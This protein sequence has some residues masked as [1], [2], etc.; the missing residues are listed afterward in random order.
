MNR[1]NKNPSI[2]ELFQAQHTKYLAALS[3]KTT[4]DIEYHETLISSN[5]ASVDTFITLSRLLAGQKENQR[6]IAVCKQGL[7]IFPQSPFLYLQLADIL[8]RY[9]QH[10]EALNVLAE[11]EKA[12]P[13]N[14]SI[15]FSH[16]LFLP[17]LYQ[18]QD[19]ITGYRRRFEKGLE[20]IENN[21]TFF[22]SNHK[23]ETLKSVQPKFLLA[24]QGHNDL[25][26][27]KRLGIVVNRIMAANYPAWT[28]PLALPALSPGNKIRLGYI[29]A[30]L[31]NHSVAKGRIGWVANHNPDRF[32][33][34]SYHIGRRRDQ[35][36]D[37]FSQNSAQF[38]HI[39]NKLE[40]ICQQIRRDDLHI[41]VFLDLGMTPKMTRLAGLRLAPIQCVTWGHPVTSG[42]PTIDYFLSS[43]LMEPEN[44][45]SHYSE[46]LVR[47]VN[48]SNYYYKTVIPRPLLTKRRSDFG[49]RPNAVVYLSCQSLFKYL[50]QYDHVFPRIAA[51]V[52]EAQFV[53]L[54][55]NEGMANKFLERMRRAFAQ[56]GLDSDAYCLVLPQQPTFDYWNLNLVSDIFL[57]TLGWSG[58]NTTLEAIACDLPIVTCPGEFMRGRH[59]YAMLKMMGVTDTIAQDENEYV[60]LAVQL[61]QHPEWRQSIVN[62]IRGRRSK[63]LFYDTQCIV[64]LET[65][66]KEAVV[67]AGQNEGQI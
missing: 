17:R 9:G 15:Y 27:Q 48:I 56:F 42:L 45:E 39:P 63:H 13:D 28:A 49:I 7:S 16:R 6:A 31:H 12:A 57:D 36:T 34:H 3:E 53:F 32:I 62:Q 40:E 20:E 22:L 10:E 47:L 41:L 5:Q 58:C 44:G 24:Y 25:H 33:V 38:H 8:N 54:T 11:G 30:H 18:T 46:K 14:P 37:R 60:R 4:S 55:P 26:L 19:E 23:K 66:Y 21:L 52:P 35:M 50:P 51:L 1:E 43:D 2:T 67:L 64:D 29:S 59:S 61:G 65:F